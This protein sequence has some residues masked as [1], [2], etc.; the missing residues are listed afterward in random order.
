M[1]LELLRRVCSILES[2]EG[3]PLVLYQ[4][5]LPAGERERLKGISAPR[6]QAQA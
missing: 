6:K 3:F 2:S 4:G 1:R 5:K